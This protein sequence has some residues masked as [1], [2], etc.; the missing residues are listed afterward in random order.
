VIPASI[1]EGAGDGTGEQ[2]FFEILSN[3]TSP[4]D[5]VDELRRTGFPAG[6]QRAYILA[7]VM[8]EHPVIVAG[9][10]HPEIVLACH[11]LTSPTL[12]SALEMAAEIARRCFGDR[13][14][15]LLAVPNALVTLPRWSGTEV[16]QL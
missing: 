15:E 12:E 5:L 6:A 11:L 4:S 1:P 7:K 16:E 3:A 14:L 8:A 10:E 9:P 13:P 2:R